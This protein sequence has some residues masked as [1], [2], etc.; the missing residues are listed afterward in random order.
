MDEARELNRLSFQARLKR[1]SDSDRS[2]KLGDASMLV[3]TSEPSSMFNTLA[4]G[5]DEPE[6]AR[7][8]RD[9]LDILKMNGSPATIDLAASVASA[10]R[11]EAERFGLVPQGKRPVM[12]FRPAAALPLRD[13]VQVQAITDPA[14]HR[15]AVEIMAALIDLPMEALLRV[16]TFVVD[17]DVARF[18]GSKDG[19]MV[20]TVAVTR[21]GDTAHISAMV[22]LPAH[23]RKGVGQALLARAI[24]IYRGRGVSRFFLSA[25]P[26]GFPMYERLGF[27][28]VCHNDLWSFGPAS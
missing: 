17:D 21:L 22:T 6:P 4:I 12:V 10:L 14:L 16:F 2:V 11:A 20:S 28:T 15:N 24:E 23:Q 18:I 9:G 26:A 3:L 1:I 19:E 27:K 8:L 5:P 25:T 7:A 13:D